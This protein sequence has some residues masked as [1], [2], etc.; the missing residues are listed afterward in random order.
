[1]QYV[2][3]VPGGRVVECTQRLLQEQYAAGRQRA[4][5]LRQHGGAV[6]RQHVRA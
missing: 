1:M 6:P 3:L 4:G 2:L 5:Q